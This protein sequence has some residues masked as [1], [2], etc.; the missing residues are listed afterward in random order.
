MAHRT[1]DLETWPRRDHFRLFQGMDHPHFSVSLDLDVTGWRTALAASGVPFFPAAVHAVS[2]AANALEPFRMRIRGE[3]VIVHDVVHPSFTVPWGDDLF[4]FCDVPFT[5]DRAEFL[6]RLEDAVARAQS[7][8]RLL[9]SDPQPDDWIF[10]SCAPWVSFTGLTHPVD[11]KSQD[12]FPRLAWGK[13]FARDG[14]EWMPFN[15]Q[16]HHGL[17]DGRHVAQLVKRLEAVIAEQV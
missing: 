15:V 8:D 12:S 5:P 7:A 4:N 14:R 11:V 1:I 6:A 17:A 3:T 13:V 10:L 2:A 16:L 9:L